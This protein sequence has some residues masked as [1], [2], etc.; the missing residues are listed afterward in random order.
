M[1]HCL[2]HLS[3]AGLCVMAVAET[4]GIICR[5]GGLMGKFQEAE[6]EEEMVF[7]TGEGRDAVTKTIPNEVSGR[8]VPTHLR[9]LP[10][11]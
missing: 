10:L 2:Q 6:E 3:A 7:L 5:R 1:G 11:S 8:E 9:V 4:S